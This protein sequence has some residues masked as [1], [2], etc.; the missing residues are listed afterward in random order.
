MHLISHHL[1]VSFG[2]SLQLRYLRLQLLYLVSQRLYRNLTVWVLARL[3]FTLWTIR[4][5]SGELVIWQNLTA[6]R[7][8]F[9]LERYLVQGVHDKPVHFSVLRIATSFWASHIQ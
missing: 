8:E 2:L 3:H 1:P 7:V 9:A 4:N 6:L 5:M